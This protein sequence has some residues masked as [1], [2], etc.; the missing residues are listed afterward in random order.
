MTDRVHVMV[1]IS[2]PD[3]CDMKVVSA[4]ADGPLVAF[5]QRWE[6]KGQAWVDMDSDTVP[7]KRMFEEATTLPEV[8]M[9]CTV[10]YTIAG[11]YS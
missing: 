8:Q 4:P 2:G 7:L 6:D 1:A 5:C 10:H 9:P 11:V 3:G